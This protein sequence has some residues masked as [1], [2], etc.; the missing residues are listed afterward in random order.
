MGDFVADA[1]AGVAGDEQADLD[2]G[3][4]GRAGGRGAHQ[5]V[6]AAAGAGAFDGDQR[7]QD[8]PRF[9]PL[10]F[11]QAEHDLVGVSCQRRD[12]A[13]AVER[14]LGD[15]AAAA[16]LP[17]LGQREL[18]TVGRRRVRRLVGQRID[19]LLGLEGDALGRGGTGGWLL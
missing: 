2:Q 16:I 1:F 13:D 19:E 17:E 9:D 8:A 7:H 15:D 12:A 14:L 3:I 4:E 6:I 10:L 11:R 18:Q 5:L